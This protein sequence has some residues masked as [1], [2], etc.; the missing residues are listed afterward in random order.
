MK[1]AIIVVLSVALLLALAAL[2]RVPSQ[3]PLE[4]LEQR[5]SALEAEC[6]EIAPEGEQHITW[7]S[8]ETLE[9]DLGVTDPR[10]AFLDDGSTMIFKPTR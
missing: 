4:D 7:G 5:I 10:W 8:T 2:V 1:D 9:L 6:L 3:E